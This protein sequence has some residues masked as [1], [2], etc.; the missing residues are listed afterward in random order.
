M[1]KKT[2]PVTEQTTEQPSTISANTIVTITIP[3]NE[4]EAPYNEAIKHL[5]RRVKLKGFRPG[6]VPT[7]VAEK[8]LEPEDIITHALDHIIGTY[9]AAAIEKNDYKPL[10]QPRLSLKSAAKG[11]DWVVEAEVA[12]RP[13][14]SIKNFA[15]EVQAAR[16]EAAEALKKAASE[17][18][19]AKEGEKEQTP[20]QIAET[21]RQTELQHIYQALLEKFQPQVPEL[22][23]H[24]E[25]QYELD[26]LLKQLKMFNLE[27]SDYLARR[28]QTEQDLSLELASSVVPRIQLT[29]IIDEI[30]KEQAVKVTDAEIDEYLATKVSEDVRTKYQA[31]PQYRALITDTLTRQKVADYLLAL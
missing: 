8:T 29:F 13:E 12:L 15:K 2:S 3:W 20:E 24:T 5:S 26:Q 4:A 11:T 27:I 14:L 30:A 19:A 31:D 1:A 6:A 9:Y 25:M 7:K 23:A 28:K 22:L 16:K 18:P 10:T 17:K 21:A